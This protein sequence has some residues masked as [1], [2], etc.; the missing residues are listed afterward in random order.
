MSG[1]SI[2][3][4]ISSTNELKQHRIALAEALRRIPDFRIVIQDEAVA[5]TH[6]SLASCR[7]WVRSADIV[8]FLMGWLYGSTPEGHHCSFCEAEF[9]EAVE[10]KHC[11][12]FAIDEQQPFSAYVEEQSRKHPDSLARQ[13]A[14]K[15]RAGARFDFGSHRFHNEASAKELVLLALIPVL[16]EFG[17]ALVA[18]GTRISPGHTYSLQA[19]RFVGRTEERLELTRWATIGSEPVYVIAALGG[20]G[21]SALAWEWLHNDLPSISPAFDV[22]LW[23]SF[24]EEGGTFEEFAVYALAQLGERRPDELRQRS[25][26]ANRNDLLALIATRRVLIVLDGLERI[27]TGYQLYDPAATASADLERAGNAADRDVDALLLGHDAVEME[28]RRYR[29]T[30]GACRHFL[31]H[32]RGLKMSRC[33]ITSRHL[34]AEFETAQRQL[35]PNVRLRRDLSLSDADAVALMRELGATGD[36]ALLGEV[37][38]SV[39]N[40]ALSLRIFSGLVAKSRQRVPGDVGEWLEAHPDFDLTALALVQRKSHI[41]KFALKGLSA[42]ELTAIGVIAGFRGPARG[43]HVREILSDGAA[44]LVA[45]SDLETCFDNLQDRNLIGWNDEA[46]SFDMH[47]IVRGVVWRGLGQDGRRIVAAAYGA[48]FGGLVFAATG[49]GGEQLFAIQQQFFSLIELGRYLEAYELIEPHVE[50]NVVTGTH[51]RAFVEMLEALVVDRTKFTTRLIRPADQVRFL[52]TLGIAYSYAGRDRQALACK[53]ALVKAAREDWSSLRSEVESAVF[54][55]NAIVKAISL[56]ATASARALLV[57]KVAPHLQY[58][59]S[60]AGSEIACSVLAQNYPNLIDVAAYLDVHAGNASVGIELLAKHVGHYDSEMPASWKAAHCRS[61]LMIAEAHAR[62]WIEAASVEKAISF[63]NLALMIARAGDLQENALEALSKCIE[64]GSLHVAADTEAARQIESI[65][66]T[67]R[68]SGLLFAEL[69]GL[70]AICRMAT[71]AGAWDTA[72]KAGEALLEAVADQDSRELASEARLTVG[73]AYRAAGEQARAI[74]LL[75]EG[76]MLARQTTG[77]P[78][79]FYLHADIERDL[80]DMGVAPQPSDVRQYPSMMDEF[81]TVDDVVSQ[82]KTLLDR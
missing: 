53:P 75:E 54:V 82:L 40:H 17:P 72:L 23:W 71:A 73:R 35:M 25:V 18:A 3:V 11:L 31:N 22:A 32:L 51:R 47:P 29:E 80:R 14:F 13:R 49:Q 38:R 57:M 8:I 41:L 61:C 5:R 26:V 59:E 67:A 42:T 76:L 50:F 62:G 66:E 44:T 7:E 58:D 27:M 45:E 9:E 37:A 48:Y 28:G 21:K 30:I 69:S 55:R 81:S 70:E 15:E 34:P 16:R 24:Y 1:P 39:G 6:K 46:E 52:W 68:K 43:A 65:V 12:I 36:A 33:L 77:R 56:G 74:E 64:F 10:R 19:G 4:M 79:Y 60:S 2:T 78:A 20:M 63:A